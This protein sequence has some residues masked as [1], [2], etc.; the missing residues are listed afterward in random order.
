MKYQKFSFSSPAERNA[1]Q[2]KI[3]TLYPTL[4]I[5]TCDSAPDFLLYVQ[6]T[7]SVNLNA[8]ISNFAGSCCCSEFT[9]HITTTV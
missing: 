1:A 9:E 6:D 7:G 3:S 5:S 8:Q 4:M 2:E